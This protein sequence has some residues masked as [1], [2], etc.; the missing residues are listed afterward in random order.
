MNTRNT[1]TRTL[2]LALATGLLVTACGRSGGEKVVFDNCMESLVDKKYCNCL[3]DA[4]ANT[5]TDEDFEWL[6]NGG[7]M[8]DLGAAAMQSAFGGEA[9]P[10]LEGRMA[11]LQRA[12]AKAQQCL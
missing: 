4:M 8:M 5:L 6:G 3:T 7:D 12:N 2:A 9:D 10:E 11:R 1:V